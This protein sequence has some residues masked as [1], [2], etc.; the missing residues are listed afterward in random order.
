MSGVIF[1]MTRENE[2]PPGIEHIVKIS[3]NNTIN[4]RLSENLLRK[5]K[6]DLRV[7]G[8]SFVASP[9]LPGV[10]RVILEPKAL[11]KSHRP[12]ALFNEASCPV[13]GVGDLGELFIRAS[14]SGLQ[15]LSH[16]L[17][18]LSTK[19]GVANISTINRITPYTVEDALY[20]M[21]TI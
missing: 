12:T 13:I 21:W 9:S 11:A 3:R 8:T 17:Q 19:V 10:S 5:Q 1:E 7:L 16:Q 2:I 4:R 18:H 15:N 14:H 20:S 6:Q